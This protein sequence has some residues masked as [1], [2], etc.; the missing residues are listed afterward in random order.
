MNDVAKPFPLS[1]AGLD[2][3]PISGKR[4]F[5]SIREWR[6]DFIYFVMVDRF[7]DDRQR[8]PV[9]GAGR[10]P[11]GGTAAQLGTFS[12][13]TLRGITSHID[14][15]LGLGCTGI[16][17]SPIFEN[18]DDPR[19]YH[20]YSIQNYLRIDPHFGDKEDLIDL[21][22][23]AHQRDMRVFLDVVINHTGDVWS[24]QP[25]TAFF[26]F[27]DLQFPFGSF[28]K[29]DRPVP[30][31]L[32]NETLFHRRGQIRNFDAFPEYE[33]GDF[34]SLKD[35]AHDDTAEGSRLIEIL[36]AA[37]CY[38]IRE[39]DVDGFRMDAVKHLS[40]LATAR[41][42]SN[43]REYAYKLGKR[44]FLTFGELI[45][46]DDAIDRFIGPNTSSRD[47]GDR[48]FFGIESILDFP[49][50]FVVGNVIKGLAPPA[51]LFARYDRQRERAL[52][53]GELGQYL[54]TF[55]DNHDGV[56]QPDNAKRRFA[57][58]APDDQVIAGM[59]FLL[60]ALGTTCIYYGTEQAFA[61]KD[62]GDAILRQTM[63]DLNDPGKSYLN[64][65]CRIY[66]EIAKISNLTDD[67]AALK[68]G[69]MYI[70]Q[71]SGNGR[72]FGRP[73]AHPCTL[74]FSRILADQEA[75]VAYNTSTTDTRHDFV[76]VDADLQKTR[77]TMTVRYD[78]KRASTGSTVAI[79]AH[80][81]PANPS[82]SIQ[83]DLA[84]MQFVVLA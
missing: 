53:E 82:R 61:G 10:S 26:Y 35:L 62:A 58:D 24:Y 75:V 43:V 76:V 60:C 83:L 74:A 14:Y 9:R 6:E 67:I 19:N 29:P 12:G 27:N 31:E 46:G 44:S 50:Y 17:L 45:A 70:R 8:T 25:D 39:A 7:H 2:L 38:W 84:P 78:S 49:L 32:R 54:V 51:A 13:G 4:Y 66:Q 72:D 3:A 11:G 16:W 77:P 21:V 1:I 52:N 30:L 40:Q 69:R 22:E 33:R 80:P 18:V 42:C 37:H 71:V 34:F 36:T 23:A 56:G 47:G 73:Q 41:F 68:Y 5:N 59:G 55:L 64:D 65:Q 57:A 20:G 63:F 48:V 15:I 28:R 81:D 79:R